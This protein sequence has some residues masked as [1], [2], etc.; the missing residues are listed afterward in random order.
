MFSAAACPIR[1]AA[2]QCSTRMRPPLCGS[3]QRAISPAAKMPGT[4]SPGARPPVRRSPPQAAASASAV[5]GSTPCRG[6]RRSVSSVPRASVHTPGRDRGHP[7][8]KVEDQPPRLMDLRTSHR[9][10]S[11]DLSSGR[12][13]GATTCTSRLRRPAPPRPP[14]HEAGA[15]QHRAPGR[16]AAAMSAR[17][18][19]Q[20]TQRE[21]LGGPRPGDRR[22]HRLGT[23][24]HQEAVE[25][26]S[27]PLPSTT[28]RSK[29]VNS[30][31][32]CSSCKSI[33]VSA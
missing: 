1:S 15:D 5:R 3:G 22:P 30:L 24:G 21:H 28:R 23:G 13:L 27:P 33:P 17:L 6:R 25:G 20:R 26:T 2:T 18:S 7:L 19:A 14:A 8:P 9:V 16:P 12:R 4:S 11:Q 10:R 32:R 31:Q 29:R